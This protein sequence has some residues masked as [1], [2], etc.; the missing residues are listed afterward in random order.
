VVNNLVGFAYTTGKVLL[1]SDGS[2]WRPLVHIADIARAFLAVLEAPRALVHN[3]AFNVGRSE[4]NYQMRQVAEMVQDVVPGSW[5]TYAEGAEPDRRCYRVDC[6]KLARTL[7]AFQP[8]WTV[9]RGIEELYTAYKRYNLGLDEFLGTRYLRIKHITALQSQG[10]LDVALRWQQRP[11]L[12][13][14]RSEHV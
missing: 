14:G 5:V 10:Q 7:P 9:R 12:A 8:Q 13:N 4:E 11:T 2:P 3:E 1:K 6:G